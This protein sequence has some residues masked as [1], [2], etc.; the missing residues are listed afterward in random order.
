[1]PDETVLAEAYR[2]FVESRR[3][4][5]VVEMELAKTSAKRVSVPKDLAERVRA[6][7]EE[8][9]QIRWDD[10]VSCVAREVDSKPDAVER[11]LP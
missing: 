1:V 5:K 2:L 7:L 9:P 10:A 4:Q 11:R 3:V 8:R 6:I